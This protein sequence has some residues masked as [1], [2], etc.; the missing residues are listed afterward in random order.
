MED[1]NNIL[2]YMK[3]EPRTKCSAVT[4]AQ[5]MTFTT[6]RRRN[7]MNT[8]KHNITKLTSWLSPL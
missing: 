6:V 3:I 4:L 1:H 8:I 5:T 2:L 7:G